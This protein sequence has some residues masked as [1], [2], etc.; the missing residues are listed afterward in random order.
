MLTVEDR[1]IGVPAADVGRVFDKSFTGENG[2]T[3]SSATGMGLFI[4]RR[5]CRKLGHRIWMESEQ[6]RYTKVMIEFGEDGY[7]LGNK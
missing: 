6:G 7:Y 4:C 3:V 1:G 2:R 5:M